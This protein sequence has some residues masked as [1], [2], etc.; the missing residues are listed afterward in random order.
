MQLRPQ[1]TREGR[2]GQKR[3][4]GGFR[5]FALEGVQP[6]GKCGREV[7]RVVF[8]QAKSCLIVCVT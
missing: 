8:S 5:G 4:G 6:E 3:N 7:E 2:R 1:S